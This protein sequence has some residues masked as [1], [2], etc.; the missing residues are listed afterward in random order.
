MGLLFIISLFIVFFPSEAQGFALSLEPTCTVGVSGTSVTLTIQGW[1]APQDC[2]DLLAGRPNFFGGTGTGTGGTIYQVTQTPTQPVVCE[3]D[4]RGRHVIVREASTLLGM[5]VCKALQGKQSNVSSVA[6]STTQQ[7]S[8]AQLSS[9]NV[10]GKPVV[11][12]DTWT[13]TLNSV[14]M[15][16]G[17][18]MFDVPKAGNTFLV[19]NVTLHNTSSQSQSTS[20]LTMFALKDS[21]GQTYSQNII[22]G[23]SPDGT[24]VAGDVI[25]GNIAYEVPTSM[26]SFTFQFVPGMG[27]NDLAEWNVSI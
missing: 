15:S 14:T 8:S 1:T 11:A 21:T 2:A 18:N 4:Y 22:Y 20:S 24:V 12:N 10:I 6:T 3:L 19:F 13:V 7:S 16:Q 17:N 5:L 26:H 25:R 9:N 23:G 27:S